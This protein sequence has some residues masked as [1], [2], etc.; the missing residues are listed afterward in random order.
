MQGIARRSTRSIRLLNT[1]HGA[2]QSIMDV[3]AALW[4]PQLFAGTR[5]DDVH[6]CSQRCLYIKVTFG[7]SFAP[8]LGGNGSFG[9]SFGY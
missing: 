9:T 7:P 2:M 1:V 3:L 6:C 4:P 8:G 5:V